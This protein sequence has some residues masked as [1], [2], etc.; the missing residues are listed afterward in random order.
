MAWLAIG[1]Q[2][3]VTEFLHIVW[4]KLNFFICLIF[5]NI[6]GPLYGENN[7]FSCVVKFGQVRSSLVKFGVLPSQ[8]YH[9]LSPAIYVVFNF[10]KLNPD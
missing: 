5:Q 1:S 8:T 3:D 9:Q 10:L 7:A 4:K 2:L 6:G